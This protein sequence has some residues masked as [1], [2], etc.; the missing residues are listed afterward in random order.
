MKNKLCFFGI[1]LFLMSIGGC[2]QEQKPPYWDEIERFREMD[3]G[4]PPP[5][6]AILFAGS[7]SIRMWEGIGDYFPGHAV[8]NRGFGGSTLEDQIRY[9]DDVVFPYAPR[10]IV[11]YCGENDLAYVD[12]LSPESVLAR[13]EE[14]FQRVRNNLPDVRIS[15]VS[16]KPSPNRWHLAGKYQKGN[17]LIR[18]FL[19]A[20]M[21]S[22][23]IDIWD[24]MLNDDGRP[25]PAI[26]QDDM[27]HMNEKGYKLWQAKIAPFLSE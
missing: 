6:D 7:S 14:W 13:F 15:Y 16:M 25:D 5:T 2:A 27:L 23:Y 18:E 1:F 9:L 20:K 26:F 12:T 10:Q 17:G 4:N 21:N 19:E 3:K 11:L 8:I 22:D 24:V